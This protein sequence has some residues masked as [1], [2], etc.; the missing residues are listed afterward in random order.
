[1]RKAT[2]VAFELKNGGQETLSD[3]LWKQKS[4]GASLRAI[5]DA[6]SKNLG[7]QVSHETVRQWMKAG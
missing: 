4:A 3:W 2:E 5:A 7:M 1:M 6:L